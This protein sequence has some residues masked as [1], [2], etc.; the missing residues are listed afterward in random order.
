MSSW[1]LGIRKPPEGDGIEIDLAIDGG[2]PLTLDAVEAETLEVA[3]GKTL[4]GIDNASG[5]ISCVNAATQIIVAVDKVTIASLRYEK[6]ELLRD[7][8][9]EL[10]A[11]RGTQFT[12][13]GAVEDSSPTP[14]P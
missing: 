10:L 8:L 1:V 9:K 6:A 4:A 12:D 3:L 5:R 11:G 2:D 7:H 13:S 14:V